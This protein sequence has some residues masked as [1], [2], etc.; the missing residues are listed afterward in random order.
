MS[1]YSR[2]DDFSAKSG[3]TI[4]GADVDA[5]F[6]ALV[7]AVNSKVDESREGAANGIATLSASSLVPVGVSGNAVAGGGQLPEASTSALGAVELATTLEAQTGTDAVRVLTAA[8]GRDIITQAAGGGLNHAGGVLSLDQNLQDLSGLAKTDGNFIVA[9]GTTWVAESGATA[10]NSLGLVIGVD[11]QANSAML[12]DLG[13]VTPPTGADQI[14]VSTG[15]GA[16]AMESGNTMRTSLGL[17]TGSSVTFASLTVTTGNITT[18][19]IGSAVVTGPSA[20][21]LEVGGRVA[22]IHDDAT[23]TSGEIYF[24]TTGPTG[25]LDGDIWFEHEP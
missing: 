4:L 22:L 23:I 17:G 20:N 5:E 8:T 12:D 16:F 7:I 1:D 6:D 15:A 9:N 10:R 18:A 13:V 24:D 25:G 21:R 3:Q 11:V 19:N 14:L 2:Q